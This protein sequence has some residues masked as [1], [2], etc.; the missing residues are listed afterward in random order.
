MDKGRTFINW[1]KDKKIE[2]ALGL[3]PERWQTIRVKKKEGGKGLANIKEGVDALIQRHKDYKEK[4]LT[5]V[6]KKH[7]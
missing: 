2:D 5:V 4:L 3:T 7:W 6:I 1:F